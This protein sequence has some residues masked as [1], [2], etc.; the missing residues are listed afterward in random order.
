MKRI[1]LSLF[2]GMVI[3]IG[4]FVL[5]L[6][7]DITTANSSNGVIL[8]ERT[9]FAW[10][11]FWSII[12]LSDWTNFS[13]IFLTAVIANMFVFSTLAYIFMRRWEKKS[14]LT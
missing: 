2:F 6:I 3:T 13:D 14:L 8:I 10:I 1:L 7:V 11:F 4:L 5:V 12:I 9:P